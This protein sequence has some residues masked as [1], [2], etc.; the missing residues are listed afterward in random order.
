MQNRSQ[1]MGSG[2][3]GHGNLH[4]GM[5]LQAQID[6]SIDMSLSVLIGDM[7]SEMQVFASDGIGTNM[8]FAAERLNEFTGPKSELMVIPP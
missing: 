4:L 1:F 5:I 3:S 6:L 8:L 7:I 2:G